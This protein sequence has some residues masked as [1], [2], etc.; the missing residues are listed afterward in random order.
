[1]VTSCKTVAQYY[2]QKIDID[3][4]HQFYLDCISFTHTHI[5]VC[6]HL[7]LCNFIIGVVSCIRHHNQNTEQRYYHG[8][9]DPSC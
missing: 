1:M 2:N 3:K 6:V 4:I 7:V 5:C 9:Q 8:H